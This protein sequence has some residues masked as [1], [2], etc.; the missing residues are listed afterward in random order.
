MTIIITVPSPALKQRAT[1]VKTN[2]QTRV[3]NARYERMIRKSRK[4]IGPYIP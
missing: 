1:A 4:K 2:I 3:D